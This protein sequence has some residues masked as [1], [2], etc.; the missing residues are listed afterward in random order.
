MEHNLL[1]ALSRGWW[2]DPPQSTQEGLAYA[3][4][5]DEEITNEFE[6]L[7]VSGPDTTLTSQRSAIEVNVFNETTYPVTVDVDFFAQGGDIRIDESDKEELDDLTVGPGAAPAIKVDAIAESS[8][9]FN[10]QARIL[11]PET[12][13]VITSKVLTIRSTNFN[14][15]A[16]GI[17]FGALAFL[18]LFYILRLIR[19]RR[20]ASGITA[21]STPS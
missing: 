18:I 4:D 12:R 3:T 20:R 21:E 5:T 15:I 1:V 17:T 14:Q 6:K 13:S 11:S 2:D 10:V 19:R 16:L 7:T 9:I 8:G